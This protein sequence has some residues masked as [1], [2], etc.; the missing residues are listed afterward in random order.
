MGWRLIGTQLREIVLYPE[1]GLS[2]QPNQGLN[3]INLFLDLFNKKLEDP[4]FLAELILSHLL[5]RKL[6]LFHDRYPLTGSLEIDDWQKL[7]RSY[8][9]LPFSILAIFN[10]L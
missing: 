1:T 9:L 8:R 7:N 2:I 10:S 4:L 6:R 5:K 3:K